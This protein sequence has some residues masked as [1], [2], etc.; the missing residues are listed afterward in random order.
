[1]GQESAERPQCAFE[2]STSVPRASVRR[3]LGD[4]K[5]PSN[6][7]ITAFQN[8]PNKLEPPQQPSYCNSTT[9]KKP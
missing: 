6:D 5:K 8:Y 7:P 4:A 1:M 2:V 3:A 9:T